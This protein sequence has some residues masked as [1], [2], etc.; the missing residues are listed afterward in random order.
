MT[1]FD[2]TGP[3]WITRLCLQR[4]LGLIYLA[5]FLAALY[6]FRPLL[7]E[8]GLLPVRLYLPRIKFWDA[9]SL[10]WLNHSDSAFMIAAWMGVALATLAVTGISDSFGMAFSVT[11]WFLLWLLYLSFVNVGQVFYSFGWEI[12]L[13]EAGFLTIFLGSSDTAPPKLI[14]WLFRWL[15]FRLMFGAG[16]IKLRG[17]ACWRDLTCMLYHYETQPIPNP[18]SW[19]FHHLRPVIQKGSVLFTH[20][21]ELVVPFG[22]FGPALVSTVAGIFTVA[23]QLLLIL[24][25][26][27]SWL[28]YL[29][30][31]IAFSCFDDHF[32]ARFIPI[33]APALDPLSPVRQG[34]VIAW[35][36]VV[37]ILSIR[38][39]L[40]MISPG[41]IMNTSF[42]PL[43]LVNTYGAFGSVTR[44]RMEII[45]EGTDDD[46][47]TSATKW[48]EYEFKA[49]PGPLDRRLPIVAPYHLRL[50]WLM[51]FAA[52]SD[53][54]H[55]GWILNL[56]AKLLQNDTGTL[57]LIRGNPF[58]DQPPKYIRAQLYQYWFTTPEER[59]KTG[60]W[61]KRVQVVEYF[62]PLSLGQEN[63]RQLLKAQGWLE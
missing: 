9:P 45:L 30:L 16:L 26:N 29:T 32:L 41:Q 15:L 3:Y 52:M 34:V 43:N 22:Y 4:A 21:V 11:V 38:P 48:R 19:Y 31:A 61:W 35:T 8:N 28:N 54:R 12:L 57:K 2:T 37:L 7:G 10:F 13:L 36:A 47:I 44:E 33:A 53:Y 23:F 27:L 56:T 25:G 20:F 49:K 60:H 6:Q 39:V 59:A 51:W 14:I 62:P 18:L 50:D 55:Y 58:P 17:D 1:P 63:F 42:E 46:T 24:S 40:N 5:A